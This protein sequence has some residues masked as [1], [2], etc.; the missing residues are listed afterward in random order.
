MGIDMF[1]QQAVIMW[2]GKMRSRRWLRPWRDHI[3]MFVS[4]LSPD[5]IKG[6]R[7]EIAEC[8][9]PLASGPQDRVGG[10]HSIFT[11]LDTMYINVGRCDIR[12]RFRGDP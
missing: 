8:E 7:P 6:A 11:A 5:L 4:N 1:P 3:C 10:G 12:S 9:L 2:Q